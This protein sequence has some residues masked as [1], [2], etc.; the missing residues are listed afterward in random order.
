[1]GSC[2]FMPQSFK[3]VSPDL[4]WGFSHDILCRKGSPDVIGVKESQL[5]Q[6]FDLKTNLHIRVHAFPCC[7]VSNLFTLIFIEVLAMLCFVVGQS[8]CRWGQRKK[9]FQFCDL[10]TNLHIWVHAFPCRKVSN[11]FPLIFIEVLAMSCF[12]VGQCWC[13]WGQR[14]WVIPILWS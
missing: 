3:F 2:F 10:K 8:W 11:L 12:V 7:K 14:K 1:L 6:F 13:H 9:L 4:Y 5:F